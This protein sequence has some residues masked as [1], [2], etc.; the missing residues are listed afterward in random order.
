MLQ[1]TAP[2]P[3][4]K[5]PALSNYRVILI[6]ILMAVMGILIAM[7]V[8]EIGPFALVIALGL[9]VL[10]TMLTKPD[11]GLFIFVLAIYINLSAVLI[12]NYG[13]PSI[14][15]AMVVVMGGLILFRRFLFKDEYE[16]WV[17]PSLL[18][19]AYA[20]L[21]TVS[22]IFASSFDLARIMLVE[23]L[24]DALI[25]IIIILLIQRPNSLRGAVW[26]LLSAGIFLGTI[27][28]Y[29]QLTGTF[30]NNYW[31]FAQVDLFS[32]TGSRLTGPI[33]DPN[34]YAQILVVLLPLAVDRMGNEKNILLKSLAAWAFFVSALTVIF[35]YSRGGFLAMVVAIALIVVLRHLRLPSILFAFVA[36]MII[37]QLAPATYKNRITNLANVLPSS[38]TGGF[39]DR[40]IRS[41]TTENV[42]A[43]NVFRD[44]PIFGVG[45][46]NF[47]AYYQIYARELGLV[48]RSQAR[49]AHNLYLEIAAERGLAGLLM[50][51]SIVV[52]AMRQVFRA[53]KKFK[54]MGNEQMT[55]L[56]AA[57]GISLITYLVTAFFLHDA[58][59]R[60]FWVLV[61]ICWAIPPIAKNLS[62][63]PKTK[64]L[65][66]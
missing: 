12:T 26:A 50:F 45:I 33:G 66:S 43:W 60:F 27:S 46:G 38:R 49:S 34:Y 48:A 23:Y 35:T 62:I 64:P 24:K 19:G 41:R 6:T 28:C 21:G 52:L 63:L 56:S 20:V 17:V 4:S 18:L 10:L 13:F 8:G 1:S 55:G 22:L 36:I 31:G 15:K 39:V 65:P 3:E 14:A 40:S 7:T 54:D 47:N 11:I 29:Q 61:G 32:S 2:Q 58:F 44:H 53:S 59:P 42:V 37:F 51:G 30:T 57:M 16:G 25:S 5:L 9:I